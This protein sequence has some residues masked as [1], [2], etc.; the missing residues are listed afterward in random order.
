[1]KVERGWQQHIPGARK[2]GDKGGQ[3]TDPAY[4]IQIVEKALEER[5]ER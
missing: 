1:M 4:L 3:G 2:G 5:G